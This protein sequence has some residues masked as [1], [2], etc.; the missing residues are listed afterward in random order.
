MGDAKTMEPKQAP[1]LYEH[2]ANQLIAQVQAEHIRALAKSIRRVEKAALACARK[3]RLNDRLMTLPGT[4][5]ILGRTTTMEIGDTRRFRTDGDFASYGLLVDARRLSNGKCKANNNQKCGTKYL[6]WGFVEAAN[7]ARARTRIAGVGM[8][9]RR[10]KPTRCW[11][12]RRWRASWLKRASTGWPAHAIR[13]RNA[14]F[15]NR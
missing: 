8:T 10:P 1:K 2:P 13:T 15:Q 6:A 9:A 7:F 11:P 4:G 5:R 3:I 14:S 12:P